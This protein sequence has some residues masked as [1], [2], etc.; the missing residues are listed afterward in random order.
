MKRMLIAVDFSDVTDEVVAATA[1][2][3]KALQAQVRL[4]HTES[5]YLHLPAY[6]RAEPYF[7]DCAIDMEAAKKARAMAREHGTAGL[8]TIHHRLQE[9]GVEAD[10]LLIET[11]T[12]EGIATCAGDFNA[13]L[14]VLGMHRHGA[15]HHLLHGSV[16]EELL[17][18]LPCPILVVP[19]LNTASN[20]KGELPEFNRIVAA[21]AFTDVT[22]SVVEIAADLATAVE[23]R[24]CLLHTN[25]YPACLLPDEFVE[26]YFIGDGFK[27]DFSSMLNE[28]VSDNITETA[29]E[30]C[31]KA[32]HHQLCNKGIDAECMFLEGTTV[33]SLLRGGKQFQ[34]NI[35][36]LGA[37]QHSDLYHL[38]VGTVREDVLERAECPVLLVPPAKESTPS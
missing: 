24:L 9:S 33:E 28:D 25:P 26:G 27:P 2:L 22:E 30:H 37:H 13:D 1:V 19:H 21:L 38:I 29:D 8:A 3:A 17:R 6:C 15:L 32:I 4:V 12:A 31:M 11:V 10:Y 23:A 20:D 35:L 36:V 18:L 14:I 7:L 5:P 16:R 34:A